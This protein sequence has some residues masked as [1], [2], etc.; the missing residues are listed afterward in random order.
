MEEV[1][2]FK[3]VSTLISTVAVEVA[4][5]LAREASLAQAKPVQWSEGKLELAVVVLV[6]ESAK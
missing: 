5:E 2:T 6:V 4:E 3:A 1:V